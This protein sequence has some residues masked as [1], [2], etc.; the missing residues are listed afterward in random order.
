MFRHTNYGFANTGNETICG[1][2]FRLI[3]SNVTTPLFDARN[4]TPSNIRDALNNLQ[5]IKSQGYVLVASQVTYNWSTYMVSFYLKNQE[6][7]QLLMCQTEG[8]VAAEARRIQKGS[9]MS[10]NYL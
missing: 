5:P 6:E 9:A 3:Y 2:K 1:G 7:A 8:E 4:V 10:V